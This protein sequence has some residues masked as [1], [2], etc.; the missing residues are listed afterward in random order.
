MKRMLSGILN[1]MLNMMYRYQWLAIGFPEFILLLMSVVWFG[2]NTPKAN[3]YDNRIMKIVIFAVYLL[4]CAG[5]KLVLFFRVFSRRVLKRLSF[6]FVSF[7]MAMIEL[8][9]FFDLY[10]V[11][12]S[13]K[14]TVPEIIGY[15]WD[16][17]VP[18]L[19][20]LAVGMGANVWMRRRD[21]LRGI[22]ERLYEKAAAALK[23]LQG[24]IAALFQKSLPDKQRNAVLTAA[25]VV[26]SA[27][28]FLVFSRYQGMQDSSALRSRII[29]VEA[30][31]LGLFVLLFLLCDIQALQKA[32]EAMTGESVHQKQK[33][34]R[35]LLY[36]PFS[37]WLIVAA[38]LAAAFMCL[39]AGEFGTA[40][41][42]YVFTVLLTGYFYNARLGGLAAAATAAVYL[43]GYAANRYFRGTYLLQLLIGMLGEER[44]NRLY[45]LVNF[46]QVR[47]AR[48]VLHNSY[49]I[50]RPI[51]Y[52]V[53][54]T[55][56]IYTRV[57]DFSYLNLVSVFGKCVA[58]LVIAWYVRLLVDAFLTLERHRNYRRKFTPMQQR[59]LFTAECMCLYIMTH[60]LVHVVSNLMFVF[61][62]GVSLPFISKGLSNLF[63]M[64]IF[65]V[66]IVYCLR[67]CEE[68]V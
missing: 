43:A 41:I 32:K 59:L 55:G 26:C 5:V 3:E 27:V 7:F 44:W 45:G 57:E 35:S 12:F 25:V 67:Q 38:C 30:A 62:T 49:L 4:L 51:P 31:K 53:E 6:Q 18:M 23:Q 8:G 54:M 65:S 66:L 15:V 13:E 48:A 22:P 19:V 56:R 20:I 47:E 40:I 52:N 46:T 10:I 17:C 37:A 36:L 34:F 11:G 9:W 63:V 50:P 1:S 61:F 21:I 64:L 68:D 24:S 42:L 28:G 16:W 58:L 60:C 39:A 14:R 2:W 29:L 33:G